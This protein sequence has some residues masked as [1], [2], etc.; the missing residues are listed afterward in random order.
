M[1][2]HQEEERG[3]Q[4]GL[5]MPLLTY[6]KGVFERVC[7]CV[8]TYIFLLLSYQEL[9][10][11]RRDQP[12]IL[13]CSNALKCHGKEEAPLPSAQPVMNPHRI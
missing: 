11:N 1:R 4:E 8:Y 10:W 12:G 7:V 6:S 2:A 9:T 13:R 5:N 3:S